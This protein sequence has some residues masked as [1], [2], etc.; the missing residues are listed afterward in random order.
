MSFSPLVIG[1][2][3]VT[4]EQRCKASKIYFT[5]SPLVIGSISVTL[6]AF[7]R[8]PKWYRTFSPLVIGSISVTFFSISLISAILSFSPLVIGSISVTAT[9]RPRNTGSLYSF[10][11]PCHRVNQCNLSAE[12]KSGIRKQELSVPLSSGQSV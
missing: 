5:F 12:L 6:A 4:G 11:S 1:S 9:P 2:I 7:F 3:S 8:T 10:Q